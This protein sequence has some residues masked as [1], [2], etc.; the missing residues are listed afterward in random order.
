MKKCAILMLIALISINSALGQNTNTKR[1]AILETV[2]KEDKVPYSIELMIRSQL[3]AAIAS[4]PGYEAYDRVDVSTVMA[5]HDFQ[6]NGLVSENDIKRLG[7]MTGAE[8]VLVAEVAYLNNSY[9]FIVAKILNVETAMVEQTAN[10]Q[11]MTTV[12]EL[13]KGCRILT[14]ELLNIKVSETDKFKGD[15]MIGDTRYI[16]EYSNGLPNGKGVAYFADGR[17]YDG[18]WINGMFDGKGKLTNGKETLVGEFKNG[19]ANGAGTYYR[20]GIKTE[21]YWY[22]S[23]LLQY[24]EYYDD[25]TKRIYSAPDEAGGRS[26]RNV[27]PDGSYL[28][29][30]VDTLNRFQGNLSSYSKD[31]V[32]LESMF[33]D[34]NFCKECITYK[35]G[36]ITTKEV[37]RNV[38]GVNVIEEIINYREG[39]PYLKRIFNDKRKLVKTIKIK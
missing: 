39:K 37:F 8:F 10:I 3:G 18:E 36:I 38:G 16:G 20:D 2:D 23:T 17:T 13:E 21:G 31:G 33:F 34:D 22:N 1:I 11:T 7:E 27:A 26:V 4:T 19:M 6:R 5:E 32:L 35:S 29:Y 9:I 25:G 12:D 28:L 30:Y 14:S 24:I 15:F